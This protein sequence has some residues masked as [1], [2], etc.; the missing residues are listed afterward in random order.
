MTDLTIEQLGWAATQYERAGET[1]LFE[2][3]YQFNRTREI[4]QSLFVSR[5]G[6][7]GLR[8]EDAFEQATKFVDFELKVLEELVGYHLG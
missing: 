1:S 8:P 4:A 7:G 5:W 2:A 3:L 6:V